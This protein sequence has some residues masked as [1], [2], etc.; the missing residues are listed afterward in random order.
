VTPLPS[1]V[2]FPTWLHHPEDWWLHEGGEWHW[3]RDFLL[4]LAAD[5][6]EEFVELHDEKAE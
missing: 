3:E 1:V 5:V 4:A 2:E 6:L